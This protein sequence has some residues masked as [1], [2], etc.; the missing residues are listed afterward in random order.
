MKVSIITVTYNCKIDLKETIKSVEMQ[1]YKNIEHI[2]IDGGST[3]GTLDLIKQYSK[4]DNKVKYIS[5]K[6]Y[7]IYDAM[8]KGIN[9]SNGDIIYFL[10]AKDIFC[11]EDVITKIVDVFQTT[12]SEIVYGNII[13]N[14]KEVKKVK[15]D[16]SI[17]KQIIMKG[18]CHQ[19]IFFKKQSF[20]RIGNF[21]IKYKIS[22]DYDFIIRA[23]INKL[24]FKYKDI[25][26]AIYD[27][28]GVSSNI[29]NHKKAIIEYKNIINKNCNKTNKILPN[30]RYFYMM[31]KYY[32]RKRKLCC[33][34]K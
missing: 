30:M 24:V 9:I 21:D 16:N 1:N 29:N 13:I 6:D 15:H 7:G 3:D 17:K 5:E 33:N 34:E 20:D 8:N 4:E 28:N 11:D 32:F 18:I 31:I 2:I 14:G 23:F 22:A 25:D 19:S 26:I 27:E 10:N 12:Q